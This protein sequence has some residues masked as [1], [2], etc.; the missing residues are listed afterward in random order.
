MAG[1]LTML[2]PRPISRNLTGLPCRGPRYFSYMVWYLWEVTL[3]VPCFRAMAS[4]VV[5]FD[6][7]SV[8]GLS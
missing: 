7:V 8:L 6:L 1:F 3:L 2:H 4:K 5:L